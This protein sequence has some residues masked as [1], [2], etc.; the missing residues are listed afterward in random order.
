MDTRINEITNYAKIVRE[1]YDLKA[2]YLYGSLAKGTANE[3]SDID[4]AIVI[5]PVNP[6]EYM[7]VLS[8][9]FSIAADFESSIE[10][11]LLVDDGVYNKYSFLAEVIETGKLIGV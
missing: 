6:D 10:P 9:L 5:D 7:S 4:V 11:N 8:G 1:R 3:H 2:I